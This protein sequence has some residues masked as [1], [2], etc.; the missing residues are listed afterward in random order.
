MR[1]PRHR[2][3][4]R[5]VNLSEEPVPSA[6][7]QRSG[8]GARTFFSGRSSSR[9]RSGSGSLQS[10]P[11]RSRRRSRSRSCSRSLPRSFSFP[12]WLLRSASLSGSRGP[13]SRS[14]S[15]SGRARFLARSRCVSRSGSFCLSRS[16]SLALSLSL[17]FSRGLLS[18]FGSSFCF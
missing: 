4:K 7:G 18:S 14:L 9:L 6:G 10:S 12:P 5:G 11:L 1:F 8:P 3:A 13:R 15:L 2:A 17:S 16:F